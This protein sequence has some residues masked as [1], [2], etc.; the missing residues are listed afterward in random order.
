MYARHIALVDRSPHAAFLWTPVQKLWHANRAAHAYVDDVV[1]HESLSAASA[2]CA[3]TQRADIYEGLETSFLLVPV[4]D[5]SNRVAVVL[6]IENHE[7]QDIPAVM[8]ALSESPGHFAQIVHLLPQAVLTA[9]PDGEFDYASRRWCQI[10]GDA[11]VDCDVTASVLDATGRHAALF[12][13]LWT[14]GRDAGEVF[15]FEIP[16]TTPRGER[17]HELRAA[18]NYEDGR[19]LKWIVTIDDVDERVTAREDLSRSRRRLEVLAEIGRLSLDTNLGEEE[20]LRKGLAAAASVID[21][22]W[23]AAI[24]VA[25][26]C[27]VAVQ[28]NEA[29]LLERSFVPV[30]DIDGISASMER[31]NDEAARPT[32]R[33]PLATGSK[34]EQ[35]AVIGEPGGRAFGGEEVNLVADVAS[36]I[37]SALRHLREFHRESRIARVLQTAMLPVSLPRRSGVSFDVA[38]HP[39]ES[40]ALVG[41]DWYDAFEL[42]DG[43]LAF[44]IGDVAGHGLSAAVV[45]GHV[46]EIV[47]LAALRG[48]TPAEVLSV[49]NESII[50]GGHGLV[51]AI[52]GYFDPMTLA[53]EYA[54]AG[55]C[56]P[57][58]VHEGGE[59]TEFELGDVILGAVAGARYRTC[60]M[61]MPESSSLVLYTD[62]LIEYS[63]DASAGETVLRDVLR[64]WGEQRFHDSASELVDRCLAG[65]A[66]QDDIAVLVLR[67]ERIERMDD[68]FSAN[69]ASARR[70]RVSIRR[71][72]ARASL[73]G[74]TDDLVLAMCEAVNNAIEH[75]SRSPS[76]KV[77][78]A[79]EWDDRGA[80]GTVESSGPWTNRRPTIE[81]GRGLTLMRALTDHM[82]INVGEG[83]T[84]VR[85]YVETMSGSEQGA[86]HAGK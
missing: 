4:L 61:E 7:L 36:R 39:A 53:L 46:R 70:A 63:H 56:L 48:A 75:G 42:A 86:A 17:W 38:Y 10:T 31:W 59:V 13:R 67:A 5:T 37:A 1:Q 74:R 26:A 66:V 24:D 69:L 9:R 21:A 76:E 64:T 82:E 57:M 80:R 58:L 8:H 54:T 85:L 51:T 65:A 29:R 55:H 3:R 22:I 52:V 49:T 34:H 33:V 79:L 25:G 72:L 12:R 16:L 43:R 32:L 30:S 35:L 78:V 6:G 11:V 73:G 50:A 83:G 44:S 18:P 45:M 2:A 40:D 41:G 19:L 28:P 81:R 68:T 15:S 71:A 14:K 60:A 20:L 62:G 47:R 27:L 77:R 84:S 23:M